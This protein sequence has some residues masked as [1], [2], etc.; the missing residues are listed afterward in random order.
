MGTAHRPG[1]IYRDQSG[2]GFHD[3]SG[4]PIPAEEVPQ[5]LLTEEEWDS[6][7]PGA[8]TSAP[9]A[10]PAAPQLVQ[11]AEEGGEAEEG[12]E[13]EGADQ[14]S[15]GDAEGAGDQPEGIADDFPGAAQLRAARVTT[16]QAVA[17]HPDILSIDGIGPKRAKEILADPRIVALQESQAG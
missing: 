6:Q 7:A 2:D 14:G 15:G 5:E 12:Q 9:E 16:Y 1:G 17:S 3:A 4:N 11:E 13:D 8:P 10:P